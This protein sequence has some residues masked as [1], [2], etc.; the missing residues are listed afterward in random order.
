MSIPQE[1]C[2]EG[3]LERKRSST[4]PGLATGVTNTLGERLLFGRSIRESTG[5]SA[6]AP[7]DRQEE[8][9]CQTLL[10]EEVLMPRKVTE[11]TGARRDC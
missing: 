6:S 8:A 10:A 9:G 11:I 3:C 7:R 5:S 1:S 2:T 4:D